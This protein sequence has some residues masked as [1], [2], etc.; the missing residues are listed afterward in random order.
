MNDGEP[1]KYEQPVG[2]GL[3]AYYPVASLPKLLDGASPVYV[4][5][6]EKKAIALSQLD[7][8]A[9]GIGGVWAWKQK[10]TEELIPDL[11]AI[12]WAGRDVF[13]I[14]DHDPKPTTR[15]HVDVARRR[16]AAALRAAGA[17]EV[18]RVELPPGPEGAKQGVDDYLVA[19][20][21]EAFFD[22]VGRARSVE[23]I[24]QIHQT[25]AEL[26]GAGGIQLIQLIPPQLGE[27]A[28][29]GLVGEFLRA[30][31]TYTE[32]TDAGFSPTILPAVGTLRSAPARTCSPGTANRH[33]SMPSLWGPRAPGGRG[34]H[35]P[36]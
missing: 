34:P 7:L 4:T 18:Y 19:S 10:D 25:P 14:F 3:H 31:A 8:A 12:P 17:R 16:L 23:R 21:A 5:E 26:Q 1:I 9:V 32:A 36:P 27:D 33:A 35:S 28:S 20:G 6:G 30:V 29:H 15:H 11:T 13:V 22:L 2:E 24:N